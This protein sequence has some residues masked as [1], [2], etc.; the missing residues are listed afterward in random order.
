MLAE[1]P[2]SYA[3]LVETA[4]PLVLD[5]R[6]LR[7]DIVRF[8]RKGWTKRPRGILRVGPLRRMRTDRE[9]QAMAIHNRY[10]FQAVDAAED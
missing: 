2:T 6:N 8:S 5:A 10:D 4:S 9:G 3:A 7:G 1:K